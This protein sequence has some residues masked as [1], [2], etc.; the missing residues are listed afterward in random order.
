M[1]AGFSKSADAKAL[2]I[3][4]GNSGRSDD[5]LGWAFVEVGEKGGDFLKHCFATNCKLRMPIGQK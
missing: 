4:I 5:G 3:G 1:L 2:M